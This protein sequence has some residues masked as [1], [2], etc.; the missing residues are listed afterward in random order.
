PAGSNSGNFIPDLIRQIDANIFG[1]KILIPLDQYLPVL[2]KKIH[3]ATG[4]VVT[5]QL[6]DEYSQGILINPS[7]P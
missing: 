6:P 1:L 4:L 3:P 7:D 2:N 5:D